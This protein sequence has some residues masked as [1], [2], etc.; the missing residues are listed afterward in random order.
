MASIKQTARGF[1]AQVYVNGQRD[2]KTCRTMREAKAWAAAREQE[3]RDIAG[4]PADE[5]HTLRDLFNRYDADV[6]PGKKSKK[7]ERACLRAFLRNFP[8]LADK[9]LSALSASDLAAWRDARLKTVSAASVLRDASWMMSAFGFARREWKWMRNNP[10]D[11][12]TLPRQPGP[13]ERRVSV[14][15]VRLICRELG[16]RPGVEPQNKAQEVALVLLL[17]IRTAMR[18]SEVVGLGRHNVDLGR[19]VA[20]VSHKTE[21]L[22]GKPRQVPLSPRAMRLLRTVAHRE[23]FFT[24]KPGRLGSIFREARDKISESVPSIADLHFHDS[25]AEALTRLSRKVDVMTLAKISGH[26][27]I[28]ILQNTYYRESAA[29]IAARL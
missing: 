18:T 28:G 24:V 5:L 25:R 14:R 10:F 11:G 23:R 17:A 15:E 16:Y 20:T 1:R 8:E 21:H 2:S 27:N 9:R 4:A 13:R 26:K 7:V 22:T 29:D 12:L 19:R 3:L 6:L